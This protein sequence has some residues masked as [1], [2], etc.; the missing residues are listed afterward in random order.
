[1]PT[2]FVLSLLKLLQCVEQ[3]WINEHY[4][5]VFNFR[6]ENSIKNDWISYG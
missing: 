1:M 6:I 5:S 2:S 3:K 4:E